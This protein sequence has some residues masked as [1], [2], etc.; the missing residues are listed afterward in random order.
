MEALF[1]QLLKEKI[2]LQNENDEKNF[3]QKI[4]PKPIKTETQPYSL[5]NASTL[6]ISSFF[7]ESIE[8]FPSLFEKNLSTFNEC[9]TDLEKSAIPNKCV[10]AGGVDNIWIV[11]NMKILYIAM[12]VM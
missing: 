11:L 1:A 6:Q 8:K 7:D 3:F 12:I 5:I 2:E 4:N 9:L 10:C